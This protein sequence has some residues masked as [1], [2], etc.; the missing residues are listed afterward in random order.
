MAILSTGPIDNSAVSGV[1]P[2]Q[3][4]TVKIDNRDSVNFS[5]VL[6]EKIILPILMHLNLFLQREVLP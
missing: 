1:R 2:T 5:T 3:Q 4:V 6:I